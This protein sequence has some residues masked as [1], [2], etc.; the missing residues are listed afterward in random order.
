MSINNIDR[1]LKVKK[2]KKH[3]TNYKK[4]NQKVI[5]II[6]FMNTYNLYI[7]YNVRVYIIKY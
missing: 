5:F 4:I 3:G 2:K 1:Y 7:I 6:T